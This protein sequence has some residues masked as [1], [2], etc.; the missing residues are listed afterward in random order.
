MTLTER[1]EAMQEIFESLQC[2]N[3][4]LVKQDI[5]DSI[6][7]ELKEDFNFCLEVLAGKHKLGYRYETVEG[8]PDVSAFATIKE[9]YQYL[10]KPL[11]EHDLSRANIFKHL[12]NTYFWADFLEPLCNREYRLG[13]GQ[14]ILNKD[15]TAPMLAKKYEGVLPYD[16]EGYYITE[17]LDGNR[18]IAYYENDEWHFVSRNGKR[19]N[20]EFDM[21]GLPEELI[22]DG[23][24]ISPEQYEMSKCIHISVKNHTIADKFEKDFNTTSGLINRHTTKKNLV[25]CIFDIQDYAPYI[26]RRQLLQHLNPTASNVAILPLLAL[27]EKSGDRIIDE[28]L[29]KVV[30]IGGE[31]IMLNAG[32]ASYQNKRTNVL[33]KYKQVQTMDMEVIDTFEGKGKY[34]G[35]CGGLTCSAKYGENGKVFVDV[36]TGLSD[37]QRLKWRNK[38][39]I[40]GKIVEVAY[41]EL[42]QDKAAKGSNLYSLRFPRLKTVREDKNETSID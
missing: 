18:C 12:K 23:E 20:V 1:V 3:S 42:S 36:G 19:M 9:V 38:D 28:L 25:Y 14:S 35:M 16:A 31:G 8:V 5:I 10:Q 33:M 37:A 11:L 39:N 7:Q 6:P 22:Y 15:D 41:F 13:I 32:S 26:T 34:E 29:D 2:T 4:R 40:V 24:V 21:S 27:A 17:K 30:S